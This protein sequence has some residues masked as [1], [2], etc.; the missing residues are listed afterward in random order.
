MVEGQDAGGP[1]R[2]VPEEVG[3]GAGETEADRKRG[4]EEGRVSE[5]PAF[6]Q[7]F[8]SAFIVLNPT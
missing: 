2:L 5:S 3:A 1:G 8:S 7:G 4:G 6:F